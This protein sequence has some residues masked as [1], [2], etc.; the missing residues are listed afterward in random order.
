M[1]LT[2]DQQKQRQVLSAGGQIQPRFKNFLVDSSSKKHFSSSQK[3]P[4]SYQETGTMNKNQWVQ[5]TAKADLQRLKV[6]KWTD[7]KNN[8]A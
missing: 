3:V 8:Y 7:V 6:L 2:S 4:E 5:Q 1:L